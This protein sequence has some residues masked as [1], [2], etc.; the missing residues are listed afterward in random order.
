MAVGHARIYDLLGPAQAL[1]ILSNSK[2]A[3]QNETG[4]AGQFRSIQFKVS[5]WGP[6]KITA[7]ITLLGFELA[8]EGQK[9]R[10]Q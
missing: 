8:G 1:S 7:K 6:A 5:D 2:W 10:T 9:H 4:R 3:E